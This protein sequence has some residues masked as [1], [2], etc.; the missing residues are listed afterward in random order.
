MEKYKKITRNYY[1]ANYM[2]YDSFTRNYLDNIIHET[3]SFLR[4][5][6][7]KRMLDLGCGPG[8]DSLFFKSSGLSVFS[9]DLSENMAKS[10]KKKGLDAIIMD[11]EHMGFKD[12]SF[13]GVWAYTSL[14]HVPKQKID[15][16]LI[17]IYN[18]L[19]DGGV[20][21]LAMKEGNFEGIHTNPTYNKKRFSSLY[22][23]YEIKGLLS[24][25]F[26]VLSSSKTITKKD[27]YLKYLCIKK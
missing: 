24:K 17:S 7:G 1:D 2:E 23:D 26:K 25:R 19:K 18:V 9:V 20:L 5:L 14:L 11:M 10:S 13:D 3:D 27:A 22:E 8:R 4:I 16:V 6:N 15:D 21:F 12:K